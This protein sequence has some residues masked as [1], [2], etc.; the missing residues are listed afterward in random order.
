MSFW[1]SSF[2]GQLWR[3]CPNVCGLWLDIL[4]RPLAQH[5]NKLKG[6]TCNLGTLAFLARTPTHKRFPPFAAIRMLQCIL[7]DTRVFSKRTNTLSNNVLKSPRNA[8]FFET[9]A[10]RHARVQFE[11]RP[12]KATN[13]A[14]YCP[15]QP[16]CTSSDERRSLQGATVCN[17]KCKQMQTA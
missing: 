17:S 14:S 5:R 6:P 12:S 3:F 13:S 11:C 10:F 15:V 8:S 1:N 4:R 2:A 16:T 9:Q 7:F